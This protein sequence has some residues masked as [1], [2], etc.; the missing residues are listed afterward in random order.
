MSRPPARLFGPILRLRDRI[1]GW[2]ERHGSAALW[3]RVLRLGL[4]QFGMGLTLAPITGTLNRVLIESMRIP[5]ALVAL[6]I[7]IHYFVSPVR[8]LIGYRS[9][10]QR[11][12][13]RWR[14][15]YLV[16]GGLLTFGG[17]NNAGFS[18]VLLS[19]KGTL[20]F[21]PSLVICLLIFLAYGIGVNVLETAYLALVSDLTPPK[22]RGRV[23]AVLWM[24][25]VLGTI[26]SSVLLGGLLVNYTDERLIAILQSSALVFLILSVISL[27]GQER[28][29]RDGT[30][31]GYHDEVRVRMSLGQSLALLWRQPVLRQLFAIL[32]IATAA[33]ASHDILLEPYGGQVL[34]MSVSATTRLTSLW[35]LAM[36]TAIPA[37][38][39]LLW[40][41]FSPVLPIIL[42]CAV[43]ALGFLVISIASDS[44]LVTAF[45]S[46]VW[47]IGMGR[48]LFIVG[49]VAL[50]MAM[51]DRAH[52][53]LFLG[54]WGVMQALAQGVGAVGG[55]L[56]RDIAEARLGSVILGY[57]AVYG[58]ALLALL[59]ALALIAALRLAHLRPDSTT[60]PWQ[61]LQDIPADQ[62]IY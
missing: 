40:R 54:L 16:F 49:S 56:A 35:G 30:V 51:T 53:G 50:V 44:S 58:A 27:W 60:S 46:G 62:I 33:F 9:D 3:L 57:T 23:L 47:L 14:T 32:F 4:F 21:V 10:Q 38:G 20:P 52:A 2:F 39:W 22:E 15:P 36:L 25:L 17:L 42:G 24:M 34:G 11:A 41:G 12:R 13:G 8:A 26:A 28:L 37:A 43:G 6:L 59:V 19:G 31:I 1:N 18:L 7:A 55:G 61:G 5:A 48:G 45:R 29:R